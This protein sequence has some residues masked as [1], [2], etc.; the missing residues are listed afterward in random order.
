MLHRKLVQLLAW[1]I[2]V[3]NRL[4]LVITYGCS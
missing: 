1:H 3:R 4:H 2:V